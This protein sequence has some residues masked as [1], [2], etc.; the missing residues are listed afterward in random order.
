MF[1]NIAGHYDF[2][3][4]LLSLNIDRL[5][6]RKAIS[7]LKDHHPLTILDV[8]TGTGDLAI[9]AM[10]LNPVKITGIDISAEML[11]IGRDKIIKRKLSHVIELLQADSENLP[12][13]AQSFDSAIVAFGVRN[14]ENLE[15]GLFEIFRVIKPGGI[16]V[17]LEFSKPS[18]FPVKQLFQCYFRLILPFVGRLI[19]KDRTAYSY[20]PESVAA[21]PE[22][23]AFL[24]K[25]EEAG[26][27]KVEYI[28]LSFGIAALY[29]G[30]KQTKNSGI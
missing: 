4:H 9:E 30:I 8:A 25:L 15:K 12:F 14:F 3:N 1:D 23:K 29:S 7:L 24:Q 21:F 6:R 16:F 18:A 13:E 22:G 5:W 11:K 27:K 10:K 20:L 19:S 28:S 17:V 26:F 2:L